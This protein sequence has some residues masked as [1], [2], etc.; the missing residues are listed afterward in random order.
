MKRPPDYCGNLFSVGDFGAPLCVRPGHIC[1]VRPA[2]CKHANVLVSGGHD[3]RGPAVWLVDHQGQSV[4]HPVV[5]V[6]AYER[7]LASR[8]CVALGEPNSYTFLGAPARTRSTGTGPSPPSSAPRSFPDCRTCIRLP[9]TQT[10]SKERAC[11][12]C[13]LIPGS[14]CVRTVR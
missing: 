13:V 1:E 9:R 14:F 6:K 7:D 5:D 8:A 11:P 3:H 12:R 2:G 4:R 10:F